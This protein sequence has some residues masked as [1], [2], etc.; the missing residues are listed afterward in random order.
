MAALSVDALVGS[1]VVAAVISGI[2][3]LLVARSTAQATVEAARVAAREERAKAADEERRQVRAA[4]VR[5]VEGWHLAALRDADWAVRQESAGKA[6]GALVEVA[7]LLGLPVRT[8]EF[9][10]LILLL[11]ARTEDDLSRAE[12]L[13][14]RVEET[15]VDTLQRFDSTE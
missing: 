10:E 8:A 2:V 15:I 13:W 9:E 1:A 14:G 4:L 3:S 5:A 12:K 6:R 11:A 7:A